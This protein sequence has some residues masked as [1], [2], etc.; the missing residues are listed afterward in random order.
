[1]FSD[2]SKF[3]IRYIFFYCFRQW[4]NQ[5]QMC[6]AIV[7][8]IS[9][10]CLRTHKNTELYVHIANFIHSGEEEKN[11]HKTNWKFCCYVDVIGVY[12]LAFFLSLLSLLFTVSHSDACGALIYDLLQMEWKRKMANKCCGK[13]LIIF[14]L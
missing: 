13:Q 10:P 1:M 14:C 7:S 6:C 8:P 9:N 5:M 12:S 3:K 2:F 4:E 11:K